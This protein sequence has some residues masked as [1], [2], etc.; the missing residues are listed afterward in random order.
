MLIGLQLKWKSMHT[1]T[2]IVTDSFGQTIL[3]T[4]NWRVAVAHKQIFGNSNW[5]INYG[6]NF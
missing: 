5:K 4:T 6:Q 2:Y 1:T 3:Q